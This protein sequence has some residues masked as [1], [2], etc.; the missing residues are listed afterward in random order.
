VTARSAPP[1]AP[2]SGHLDEDGLLAALV[3]APGTY[4]RNR[5]FDLY[6]RQDLARVQRRARVVRS[7]VRTLLRDEPKSVSKSPE[8]AWV[9]V[10]VEIPALGLRRTARLTP[11]EFDLVEFLHARAEGQ[12]PPSPHRVDEALLRLAGLGG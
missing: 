6:Q 12:R 9:V 8:G 10:R 4:S 1:A 5:H 3:L 11:I 2:A 7:L